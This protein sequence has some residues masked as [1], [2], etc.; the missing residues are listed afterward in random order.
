MDI[1]EGVLQ[2]ERRYCERYCEMNPGTSS[3]RRASSLIY[4]DAIFAAMAAF[5]ERS[6]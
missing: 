2:K 5:N 1:L 4:Q 6:R 3:E